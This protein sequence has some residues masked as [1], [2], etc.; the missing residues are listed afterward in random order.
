MIMKRSVGL[1]LMKNMDGRMKALVQKR[2]RWNFAE[3]KPETYPGCCQVSCHGRIEDGETEQSALQ[4]EI[5]EELGAWF[6]AWFLENRGDSLRKVVS[7]ADDRKSVATYALLLPDDFDVESGI[8][9]S[10]SSAGLVPLDIGDLGEVVETTS[11]MKVIG[12]EFTATVA[13]F[14]DEKHAVEEAF[15]TFLEIEA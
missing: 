15:G 5:H 10:P 13:M 1:I 9:L 6:A 12:P 14:S 3:D 7:I 8:C 11:E 4:R 2:G